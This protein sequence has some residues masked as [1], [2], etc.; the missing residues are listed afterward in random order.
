MEYRAEIDVMPLKA[1]LDPQ[2]K[3]VG[4][5]LKN[6]GLGALVGLL[7]GIAVDL[8]QTMLINID[9]S[10]A[11]E[12][13][14]DLE[15]G[16]HKVQ[17]TAGKGEGKVEEL[18]T[19]IG[20]EAAKAKLLAELLAEFPQG[21]YYKDETG[22]EKILVDECGNQ[23][24]LIDENGNQ[25]FKLDENGNYKKIASFYT[26]DC[27]VLYWPPLTLWGYPEIV[28]EEIVSH[29]YGTHQWNCAKKCYERQK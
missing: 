9:S 6:M 12:L 11:N 3:A 27:L 4:A 16:G 25:V 2:G 21:A 17:T 19:Y 22:E 28:A 15:K 7:N 10:L 5:S 13:I 8:E 18:E 24:P 23:T 1:L 29:N 26:R 20:L 14:K